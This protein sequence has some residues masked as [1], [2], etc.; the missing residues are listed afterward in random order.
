MAAA[1][2]GTAALLLAAACLSTGCSTLGYYGQAVRGH[3]DLVQRT[4]P[5]TVWLADESTPEALRERL[6]LSQRIRDFAVSELKL[7]DNRSYR[8]YADLGRNAVVWNLVAAP[9]LSLELKTWCFVFVG[10]VG[11]RGWFSEAP[12]QAL[13]EQLRAQGWETSVYGV[14]AYS[15]LGRT[16][17]LGG[18]PLLNT[19][20]RW[21][22][23]E[24]A[25]LIFHELAHQVVYVR[26]DT[27][28]NESYATAVERIGV[29]RWLQQH[30]DDAARAEYAAL[31][32][33]REDFRRLAQATR[34]ELQALYSSGAEPDA[35]RAGKAR[36]FDAMRAQHQALKDGPW[37]GFGGYDPWFA[38]ANN[39]TLAVQAAYDELVA[40]FE[41]LFERVG[42]DFARFHA[43]VKALA[44]LPADQ[45][46][47]TLAARP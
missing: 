26:D 12:A 34:A 18:D 19:F 24:L 43:E 47:A 3:L 2:T 13:A 11:Y 9:E 7:P 36:I 5:V 41:A 17:W 20:I 8:G 31:D 22:E 14:P 44:A 35:L 21:P 6:V 28:F 33:R 32:A 42:G 27:T 37:A 4:R 15:T 30:A 25:R 23:G 45:R 38:Q 40:D 16:E 39:A 1:G 10:C 46:R 29:Q